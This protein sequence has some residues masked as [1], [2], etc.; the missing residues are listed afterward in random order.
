MITR[1]FISYYFHLI[2]SLLVIHLTMLALSDFIIDV[3]EKW[4]ARTYHCRSG[5]KNTDNKK[6]ANPP[7]WSFFAVHHLE[8]SFH[9]NCPLI[10]LNRISCTSNRYQVNGPSSSIQVISI[11][12]GTV[13]PPT[14]RCSL[15]VPT[16][17]RG[18]ASSPLSL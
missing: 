11:F 3:I 18:R 17:N 7:T 15:T 1:K 6:T 12:T 9:E 4:S 16:H 5:T 14:F 8:A 2:L 10:E 13:S